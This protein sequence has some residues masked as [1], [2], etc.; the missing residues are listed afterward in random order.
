[1]ADDEELFRHEVTAWT[2]GQLRDALAD[3]PADTAMKVNVSEEP[4]GEFVDEQVVICAGFGTIVWGDKRGVQT[5]PV[6]GIECE[7]PSGDYYRPRRAV[8]RHPDL[9]AEAGL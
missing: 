5:D 3:L 2:V 1:M 8:D 4:G 6:F 9:E 7:Y